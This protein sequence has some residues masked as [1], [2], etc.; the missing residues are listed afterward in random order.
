MRKV[1]IAAIAALAASAAHADTDMLVFGKS[2][3][4]ENH[5]GKP[6]NELNLGLGAEVS[7]GGAGWL[8]GGFVVRDS[9][10]HIG[11][12]A[13]VGYRVR[14]EFASGWHVE[15]TMRAG[16]LKDAYY[17]GVAALPSIGVGYKRVTVEATFIPRIK[18]GE[19][20]SDPTAVVWA[21]INF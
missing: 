13:Y 14:H 10:Y 9:I 2:H 7:S 20:C 3:H 21:R 1:L 16:V 5:Y 6:Y 15:A 8:A 19:R 4:F 11:G 17:T 18:V 12:A